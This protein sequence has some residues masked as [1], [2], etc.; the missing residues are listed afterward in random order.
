MIVKDVMSS[1]ICTVQPDNSAM[2]AAQLMSRHD[3][4]SIPVVNNNNLCGIITDRDIVLRCI[5]KGQQANNCKI[6]DVMSKSAVTISSNHTIEEAEQLMS[7]EQ[8]R[9]LPVV[10]NGKLEG[11]VSL[12]DIARIRPTKDMGKTLSEI[13]MK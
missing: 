11:V 12:A 10:D 4:G 2:D 1:D 9:R 7:S 5:A 8:I 13:S 3:V 6:N